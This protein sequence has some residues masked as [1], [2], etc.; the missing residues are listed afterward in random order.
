MLVL[1]RKANERIVLP[2]LGISITILSVHGKRARIGIEA[3]LSAA[4][5]RGEVR[6]RLL[7]LAEQLEDRQYL[8]DEFAE[9]PAL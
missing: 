2:D 4:I 9:C 1:T 7:R 8:V 5:Q 6:D 3:P